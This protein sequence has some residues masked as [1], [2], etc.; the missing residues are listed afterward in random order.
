MFYLESS[1]PSPQVSLIGHLP[2]A[3]STGAAGTLL[4]CL[5][6]IPLCPS[7]SPEGGEGE[8][9]ARRIL[10]GREVRGHRGA[11][12]RE[13]VALLQVGFAVPLFNGANYIKFYILAAS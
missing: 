11:L 1:V 6:S 4:S 3:L 5:R 13:G 9:L 7:P 10:G 12:L 8:T 2:N